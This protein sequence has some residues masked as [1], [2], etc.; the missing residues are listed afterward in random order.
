MK[1]GERVK[2]EG[3][4]LVKGRTYNINSEGT[5]LQNTTK[6][7]KYAVVQFDN[8]DGVKNVILKVPTR[9]IKRLD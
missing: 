7:S 1:K 5:M 2:V 8:V 9:K 4:M 6:S 3:Q